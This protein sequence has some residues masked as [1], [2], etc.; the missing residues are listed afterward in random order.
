MQTLINYENKVKQKIDMII[1]NGTYRNLILRAEVPTQKETVRQNGKIKEVE[2]KLLPSY[3]FV[4]MVMT[5]DTWYVIRNIKGVVGYVGPDRQPVPLSKA[6]IN[7]HQERNGEC[8][9]VLPVGV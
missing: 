8:S 5:R 4:K 9:N 3:V 1:Q 7:L 6:D 2:K